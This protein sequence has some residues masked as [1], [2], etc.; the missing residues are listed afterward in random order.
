RADQKAAGRERNDRE[1]GRGFRPI[2]ARPVEHLDGAVNGYWRRDKAQ[3]EYDQHYRLT[4]IKTE[5]LRFASRS[6]PVTRIAYLYNPADHTIQA[7]RSVKR[8]RDYQTDSR[9][10]R[11]RLLTHFYSLLFPFC[12]SMSS[13]NAP[14]SALS[15]VNR[16]PVALPSKPA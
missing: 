14:I 1:N 11:I 8:S 13:I 16:S 7:E 12:S 9:W 4:R 6:R 10:N 2:V 3:Q 15:L 5:S